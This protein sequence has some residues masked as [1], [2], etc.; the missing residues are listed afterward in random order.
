MVEQVSHEPIAP[1][2]VAVIGTADAAI[3]DTV[4]VTPGSQTP[5]L[6]VTVV[7]PLVAI[8]VRTANNYLT[9]LIGL[10]GAGMTSDVIPAADFGQLVWKCAGLSIAGAGFGVLK[11]CVTV[12]SKLEQKFPLM[13]GNV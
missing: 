12:F 3:K 5:N 7:T 9:I 13:T 1:L 11:D 6:V 4:A 8:A 2:Q 10:I